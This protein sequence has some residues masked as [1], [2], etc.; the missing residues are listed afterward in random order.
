MISGLG[1][2]PFPASS[3][4]PSYG[5]P[6][7]MPSCVCAAVVSGKL[8]AVQH[9]SAQVPSLAEIRERK[10][11]SNVVAAQPKQLLPNSPVSDKLIRKMAKSKINTQAAGFKRPSQFACLV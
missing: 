5:Q 9:L 6:P 8:I 4:P 7:P 2:F 10:N 11:K 1:G 3:S